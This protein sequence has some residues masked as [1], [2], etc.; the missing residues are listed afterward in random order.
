MNKVSYDQDA[1]K[2][3]CI[4]SVN[5]PLLSS[6][7][8]QNW[9]LPTNFSIT[10]EN[11]ISR[12]SIQWLFD[13]L[14]LQMDWTHM[15]KVIGAFL[16]NICCESAKDKGNINKSNQSQWPYTDDLGS[17]DVVT[18]EQVVTMSQVA[19][20][21]DPVK[22]SSI[23]LVETIMK[24]SSKILRDKLYI[25]EAQ[26]SP[27][28]NSQVSLMNHCQEGSQKLLQFIPTIV[29]GRVIPNMQKIR[30]G[31][32]SS[33]SIKS[34]DLVPKNPSNMKL[35]CCKKAHKLIMLGD[36]FFSRSSWKYEYLLKSKV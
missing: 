14:Y 30:D 2:N 20:N 29:N 18:I 1:H 33:N 21:E 19:A 35:N 26:K 6:N 11:I 3:T 9:N 8:T 15:A 34:C 28:I 36:S 12:K 22:E 25:D 13:L 10:P 24:V 16:Q 4:S 23:Q 27:A 32:A 31:C 5:Y 17:A 7:Y